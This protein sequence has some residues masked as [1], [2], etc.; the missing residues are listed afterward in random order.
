MNS[1][2]RKIKRTCEMEIAV[3]EDEGPEEMTDGSGDIFRGR[4]EFAEGILRIM[5]QYS[6]KPVYYNIT[7]PVSEDDAHRI[8]E[9]EEFSWLFTAKEDD[10]TRIRVRVM[11]EGLY[12]EEEEEGEHL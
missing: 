9:G 8:L 7:V 3:S 4:I 10:N 1:L 2:L 12:N 6:E 11:E 5:K